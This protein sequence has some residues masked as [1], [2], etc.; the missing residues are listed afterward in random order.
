MKRSGKNLLCFLVLFSVFLGIANFAAAAPI[1][2]TLPNP[3]CPRDADNRPVD[4]NKC[5]DSFPKLINKVLDYLVNIIGVVAIVMFVW[6][7]ALFLTS[8]GSE[9]QIGKARK[10]LIFAVVGTAI[11]LAAKGLIATIQAVINATPP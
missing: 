11:V 7:G 9:T 4:P 8:G 1:T 5:I 6:A 3:L 10:A 2:L